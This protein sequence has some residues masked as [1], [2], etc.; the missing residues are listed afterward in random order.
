MDL[1][2]EALRFI[3]RDG[4]IPGGPPLPSLTHLTLEHL[5]ISLIGVA[6][7]ALLAIPLG[8]WLGHIRRG[9]FI[10]ITIGNI[11][12]ALPSLAVLA[13]GVAF[14]GLGLLNVEVALVV[15]AAPPLLTNTYVAIAG[16]DDDLID[17][18]RGM[19]MSGW[20][21]VRKVEL[22]LALPL[23]FAGL[24]TATLLVI[25]TA[26]I[27]SLTGYSGSLGDI[28]AN[29]TSY[30]LSGVLGGAIC[31]AVLALAVDGLL[32]I[33]QRLL[34]PAGLRTSSAG[35]LADALRA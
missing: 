22:P 26:T 34:T 12:R 19:G 28:I 20:Q 24:R 30:H 1:L 3:A 16:V 6:L 29:E 14:L 9:S 2:S 35:A 7:S 27:S 17:A 8:V 13:I 10:A 33:A 15:L 4:Q 21:I 23:L 11:G 31:V 25:A 32:A 18:A 5:K